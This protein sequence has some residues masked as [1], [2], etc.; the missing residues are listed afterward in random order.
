MRWGG[1]AVWVL[2]APDLVLYVRHLVVAGKTLLDQGKGRSA[3]K[4]RERDE[5]E[6]RGTTHLVLKVDGELDDRRGKLK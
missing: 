2:A 5:G 6:G 3:S 1:R 4:E